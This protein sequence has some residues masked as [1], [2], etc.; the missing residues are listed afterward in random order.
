MKQRQKRKKPSGSKWKPVMQPVNRRTPTKRNAKRRKHVSKPTDKLSGL[1]PP[2]INQ[3]KINV[4]LTGT[5]F[6]YQINNF[7]NMYKAGP[8]I[9]IED[10]MDDQSLLEET[11]KVLNYPYKVLYFTDGYDAL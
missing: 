10:D 2:G 3:I 7:P 11:F 4:S 8:I 9:V 5:F 6:K 1:P